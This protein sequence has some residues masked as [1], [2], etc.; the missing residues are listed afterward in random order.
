MYQDP[1]NLTTRFPVL[2]LAESNL[3]RTGFIID[4]AADP[5]PEADKAWKAIQRCKSLLSYK[6]W[7]HL[8]MMEFVAD[9]II[10]IERDWAIKMNLPETAAHPFKPHLNLYQVGGFH[11]L[12]CLVSLLMQLIVRSSA[13]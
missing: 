2:N 1:G 7:S 6:V 13:N 10:A 4:D 12:H 8:L 9:G 5:S 11:A 3:T